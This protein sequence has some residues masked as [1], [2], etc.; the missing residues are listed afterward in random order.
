[1]SAGQSPDVRT[2]ERPAGSPRILLVEDDPGYRRLVREMLDQG[3]MA[4]SDVVQAGG[5][6]EARDRL[7]DPLIDC[8][9]V[10]LSLPDA[11]GVEAVVG[12]LDRAPDLALVVLT[13]RTDDGTGLA[14]V[15]AGAQDYLSKGAVDPCVLAR[16]VRFALERTYAAGGRDRLTGLP[17][18]PA[19]ATAATGA[20][21][22]V[23][24]DRFTALNES[25]GHD[26]GDA[27]LVEVATRMRSILR[28][29]DL[30]ARLDGDVF[31]VSCPQVTDTAESGA[32]ASLVSGVLAAPIDAGG[33]E[34]H[35]SASIGMALA[36]TGAAGTDSLLADAECALRR[37]NGGGDGDGW[38]C[39]TTASGLRPGSAPA[40]SV[41]CA[42]R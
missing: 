29:G 27:V 40:P 14:G 15:R 32:L 7:D 18:R 9:L 24:L 25:L 31:A 2:A 5:L 23:G 11:S 33:Q 8:A 13:G 12:L 1:M 38:R 36:G 35:V 39:T 28:P 37:A 41:A 6:A 16:S 17:G 42:G 19:L 30:L 3:A 4:G 22:A 26:A 34:V 20:V 21:M 10:D